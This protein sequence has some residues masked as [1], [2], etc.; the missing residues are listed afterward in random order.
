MLL[1][2][3]AGCG[4]NDDTGTTSTRYTAD[5]TAISHAGRTGE[6]ARGRVAYDAY[7]EGGRPSD[8][9]RFGTQARYY[10]YAGTDGSY[11]YTATDG[12]YDYTATDMSAAGH[13]AAATDTAGYYGHAATGG[14]LWYADRTEGSGNGRD[15]LL[16]NAD[17]RT[18]PA[19][20]D[21]AR[22]SR[23]FLS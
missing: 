22:I 3:C 9:D 1:G 8:R 21:T 12:S 11:D 13:T 15:M 4:G 10:G 2:V 23:D 17:N 16:T 6:H 19:G 20:R 14:K 5:R 18:A 7:A